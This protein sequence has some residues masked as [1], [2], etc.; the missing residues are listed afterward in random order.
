MRELRALYQN[1]ILWVSYEP[2]LGFVNWDGW[3]GSVDWIIFGGESG[4]GARDCHLNWFA[5]GLRW[6]RFYGVTPFVKQTGTVW[7]KRDGLSGKGENP[8]EWPEWMRVREFP[9]A[10]VKVP[11]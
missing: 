8:D 6:C 2:A 3:E 11:A 4:P 9:T 10:K 7:A 1:T 5:E